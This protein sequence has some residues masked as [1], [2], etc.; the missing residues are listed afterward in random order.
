MALRS[1]LLPPV[2]DDGEVSALAQLVRRIEAEPAQRATL[3]RRFNDA[4]GHVVS[5]LQFLS[6]GSWSSV[7]EFVAHWLSPP[8]TLTDI[9]DDE[10]V[11]LIER[12]QA[13]ADSDVALRFWTTVLETHLDVDIHR[14]LFQT[15]TLPA[16]EVLARAREAFNAAAGGQTAETTPRA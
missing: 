13:G 15:P 14:L 12:V 16:R 5:E 10:F 3:M 4:V 6:H 2:L 9:S 11:E 7:E 8:P 1:A